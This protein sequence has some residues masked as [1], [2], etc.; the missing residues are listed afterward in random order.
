MTD[1]LMTQ[2]EIYQAPGPD[3]TLRQQRYLALFDHCIGQTDINGIR[4]ATSKYW[5]LD[6]DRYKE[7]IKLLLSRQLE[8]KCRG[9]DR[10]SDD[11]RNPALNKIN[12]V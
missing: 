10:K 9:G 12:R 1:T 8:P 7:E 2:H 11:F 3:D 6:S 4:E 5:L